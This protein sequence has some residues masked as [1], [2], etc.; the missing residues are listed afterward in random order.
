MEIVASL[1]D[2]KI[3]GFLAAGH[4][5]VVTGWKMFEPMARRHGT[6]IVV[7]GFEPLDILAALL[8][9]VELV[10]DRQPVVVNMY[11]RC[12]SPEGNLNAQAQLWKVFT[13]AGGHWRGIAWVPD[14]NLELRDE[15]AHVDARMR[16]GL[17]AVA[18]RLASRVAP[19][20]ASAATS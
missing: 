19:P 3:E 14:G 5:A 11:P 16:F 13:L 17:A 15:F 20:S 18:S 6:P 1:P 12:V 4:A 9:L 7:A 2:T 10:R 8:R